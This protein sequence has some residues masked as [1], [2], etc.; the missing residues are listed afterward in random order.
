M[1]LKFD[2]SENAPLELVEIFEVDIF[3][4]DVPTPLVLAAKTSIEAPETGWSPP[5]TLPCNANELVAEPIT[6]L[7][8]PAAKIEEILAARS[9]S[10]LKFVR[11]EV[12]LITGYS[13]FLTNLV[14]DTPLAT[15][16]S[17]RKR[18]SEGL[19]EMLTVKTRPVLG[20]LCR[21]R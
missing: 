10:R 2:G 6:P 20:F 15:E 21:L 17:V 11:G 16:A 8:Q 9:T 3:V 12:S 7:P 13:L 14:G 18:Q 19:G 5:W 1:H 4:A